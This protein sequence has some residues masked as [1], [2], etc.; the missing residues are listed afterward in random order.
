MLDTAREHQAD[1]HFDHILRIAMDIP[2]AP[3]EATAA[4]ISAYKAHLAVAAFRIDTLKWIAAR[5]D[6]KRYSDRASARRPE[7]QSI[8]SVAQLTAEVRARNP[9]ALR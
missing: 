1:T 9:E 2:D 3:L 4:E 8:D 6:P 5:L 7:E